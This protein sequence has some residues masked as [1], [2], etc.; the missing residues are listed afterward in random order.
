MTYRYIVECVNSRGEVTD[1]LLPLDELNDAARTVD[2]LEDLIDRGD[3]PEHIHRI[4]FE[5]VVD[6]P[7]L[8]THDLYVREH[9]GSSGG[10]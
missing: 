1:S 4:R 8:R 6:D 7:P 3:A 10:E 9:S 5:R 2:W